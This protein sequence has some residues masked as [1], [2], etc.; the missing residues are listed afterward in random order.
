[1][2]LEILGNKSGFQWG[3]GCF[4]IAAEL[5]KVDTIEEVIFKAVSGTSEMTRVAYAACQN[6]H[7]IREEEIPFTLRQF[8][9]WLN[10]EDEEVGKKIVDDFLNS[11]YQGRIMQERY[12]E[13]VERLKA[14]NELDEEKEVKKKV[15]PVRK[16][17]K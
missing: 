15:K 1:M 12:D 6:Y 9:A 13:L 7:E 14:L 8:Q 3:L 11:K 10:D 2:Q 16:S 5:L 4:E 17:V